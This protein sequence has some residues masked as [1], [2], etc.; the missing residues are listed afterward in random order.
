M[1][2]KYQEEFDRCLLDIHQ[3]HLAGI[4]WGLFIPEIKDVKKTEDNL[5]I[6][7]EFFVYAMKKN[8]VLEYSQEK[9]APVFSHEEPEVVVE[10][11]LADF[12]LD[13]L[14]SEDVEKYS[15]FYGYA[16]FKH[17]TWVTLLEGTGYCIPG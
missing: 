14:P 17:D 4:W 7:K 10:H 9:G 13:E 11:I 3:Q 8:V 2:M 6:L 12:P 5:K 16:A 15:E 1:E